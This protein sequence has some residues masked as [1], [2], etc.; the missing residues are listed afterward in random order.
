MHSDYNNTAAETLPLSDFTYK[1]VC[2][3][4]IILEFARSI[5]M[6]PWNFDRCHIACPDGSW[7]WAPVSS[8]L[9][10]HYN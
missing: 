6:Y 9:R 7:N 10:Y 5:V 4:D 2:L 1:Q 8:C 3:W